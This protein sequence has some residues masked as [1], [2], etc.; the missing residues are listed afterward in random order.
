MRLGW[1]FH[2]GW[3]RARGNATL[4]DIVYAILHVAANGLHLNNCV[5]ARLGQGIAT[6]PPLED[7]GHTVIVWWRQG[8]PRTVWYNDTPGSSRIKLQDLT[9]EWQHACFIQFLTAGDDDLKEIRIVD[10]EIP[11]FTPPRQITRSRSPV[12]SPFSRSRSSRASTANVASATPSTNN[13]MSQQSPGPQQPPDPPPTQ[14]P[15]VLTPASAGSRGSIAVDDEDM[16]Q[17][18]A[19]RRQVRFSPPVAHD[20]RRRS[21]TSPGSDASTP[22]RLNRPSAPILLRLPD[23]GFDPVFPAHGGSSSSAAHAHQSPDARGSPARAASTVDYHSPAA[24]STVEYHS[25][26]S[27][28]AYPLSP[29]ALSV[30]DSPVLPTVNEGEPD[31]EYREADSDFDDDEWN[32]A[33]YDKSS[34]TFFSKMTSPHHAAIDG[35]DE[36]RTPPDPLHF[37]TGIS[38]TTSS[39]YDSP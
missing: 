6:L 28:A 37:C 11:P 2:D 39:F 17:R 5:G 4:S 15:T 31:G 25:P 1:L 8:R 18:P 3:R 35:L 36:V 10:P 30:V 23:P 24:A 19:I 38:R 34:K 32:C 7:I 13:T 26:A 27:T 33:A 29:G 21:Q 20:K 9:A 14:Q 22:G 12:Q 16:L